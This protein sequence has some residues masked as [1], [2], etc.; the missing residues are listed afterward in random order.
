M[1]RIALLIAT[2]IAM[3]TLTTTPAH[4][5]LA[6]QVAARA[7]SG[8]LIDDGG[9]D[10][11]VDAYSLQLRR[12]DRTRLAI[13]RL[14]QNLRC[15]ALEYGRAAT[16]RKHYATRLAALIPACLEED[17]SGQ[18]VCR[19]DART[20]GNGAGQSFTAITTP[21]GG[22]RYVYDDGHIEYVPAPPV[23]AVKALPPAFAQRR[24]AAGLD[25]APRT[26]ARCVHDDDMHTGAAHQGTRSSP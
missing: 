2:L 19:W 3:L 5:A 6:P 8:A 20:A 14:D 1:R 12:Y 10:L 24:F 9:A 22:K 4:A 18:A 15:T 7:C 11:S 23:Q 13:V 17:G 26:C 25:N 16:V 21:D